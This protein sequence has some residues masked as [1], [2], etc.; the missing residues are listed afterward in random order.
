MKQRRYVNAFRLIRSSLLFAVVALAGC[1]DSNSSR[2]VK[3]VAVTPASATLMAGAVQQLSATATYSD[4][5]TH[6]V[7]STATWGSSS[8]AAAVS[9]TGLVTASS[10]GAATISAAVGSASGISHITVTSALKSLAVTPAS[11]SLATGVAQQFTAIGTTNDGTTQDVTATTTWTSSAPAVA[12][13]TA[14]GGLAT[15]IA[16]GSTTITAT[17]SGLTATASLTVATLQVT[18]QKQVVDT[19]LGRPLSGVVLTFT[20]GATKINATTDNHG[21]F[22]AT[23]PPGVYTLT[24]MQGVTQLLTGTATVGADGTIAEYTTTIGVTLPANPIGTFLRQS[25]PIHAAFA[26][27]P[28]TPNS[29]QNV[30]VTYTDA[31]ATA[32]SVNVAFTGAGCGSLTSAQM[33]GFKYQQIAAVGNAGTCNAVATVAFPAGPQTFTTQ[34]R[35]EPTSVILPALTIPGG[36]FIAGDSLPASANV[37]AATSIT[38]VTGPGT[39]IN[40]ATER[41]TVVPAGEPSGAKIISFL[42]QLHNVAGYFS[43]PALQDAN[44][45]YYFDLVLNQDFFTTGGS[46]SSSLNRVAAH[47]MRAKALTA[48]GRM[49]AAAIAADD[50]GDATLTVT[51]EAT[52]SQGNVSNATPTTAPIRQVGAGT[53]QV[54]LSWDAP[55]D[56]DL[57]VFE[58]NGEEIAWSSPTA[59]DGGTLDLDSNAACDIDGIN[60]ENITWPK[61]AVPTPTTGGQQYTVTVD[62]YSACPDQHVNYQVTV[63]NCSAIAQFSGS[64]DASAADGNSTAGVTITSFP[65]TGCNGATVAGRA[66]Y[67]DYQVSVTGLSTTPTPLP[68]RDATITVRADSDASVLQIGSTDDNGNFNLTFN[69]NTGTPGYYLTVTAASPASDTTVV[70]QVTNQAGNLYIYVAPGQYDET[71]TPNNTGVNIAITLEDGAPAFN[72]FDQGVSAFR[73]MAPFVAGLGTPKQVTWEWEAGVDSERCPGSSC[74]IADTQHI[75]VTSREEGPHEYYDSVMLHEFGHYFQFNYGSQST[76]GGTHGFAQRNTPTLA[77]SEGFATFFGQT[78]KGSPNYIDVYTNGD[79]VCLNLDVPLDTSVPL[80][81]EDA[82]H[83]APADQNGLVSEALIGPALWNLEK[84]YGSIPVLLSAADMV[85]L[86]HP[87]ATIRDV[88]GW[89]AVDFM[90]TWFCLSN[91]KGTPTTGF[92][93]LI[94][95]TLQFPYDYQAP[96]LPPPPSASASSVKKSATHSGASQVH[97]SKDPLKL[98]MQQAARARRAATVSP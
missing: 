91:P 59:S 19:A 74:F 16:T 25:T 79:C 51:V 77:W 58:P 83:H 69:N 65:F 26:I 2:T 1:H 50:G 86:T 27:T 39:L 57:H 32:T 24:A 96:C 18:V 37:T 43:V 46:A 73:F 78:V 3:S 84:Q 41:F 5:S 72:I 49:G 92:R 17:S 13:I 23:L 7:S 36:S 63:N 30:T 44:G 8:A 52:D 94:N 71:K 66:T 35:V 97:W 87:A 38:S 45:N 98:Q 4:G 31:T 42:V 47:R 28:D 9:S 54:S 33:T 11:V 53:L 14:S 67:D 22:S 95:G 80:G 68:I 64:F 56:L 93:G 89:D 21:Q 15:T 10:P 6:D 82:A 20:L 48:H 29:G 40:G 34:F 81:T 70:Q 88:A 90:D 62:Y 75:Q 55:V 60:N 85:I 76:P 61:P 12:T